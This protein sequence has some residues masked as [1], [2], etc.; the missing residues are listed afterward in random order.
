MLEKENLHTVT[1]RSISR[2]QILESEQLF[3][4]G[5]YVQLDPRFSCKPERGHCGMYESSVGGVGFL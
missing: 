3:E 5:Y 2:V 1:G 4:G